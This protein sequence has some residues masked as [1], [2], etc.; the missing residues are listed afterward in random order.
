MAV[1]WYNET[2]I[3]KLYKQALYLHNVVKVWVVKWISE[4]NLHVRAE[5]HKKGPYGVDR[6]CW[7]NT[8]ENNNGSTIKMK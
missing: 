2:L 3:G 6:N 7:R 4:V 8:V 1:E 5:A